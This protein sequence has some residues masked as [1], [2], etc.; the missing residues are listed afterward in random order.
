[1]MRRKEIE[2]DNDEEDEDV[3]MFS[4][5]I[6]TIP[7]KPIMSKVVKPSTASVGDLLFQIK[8]NPI[9]MTTM[10]T[11]TSSS[12]VDQMEWEPVAGGRSRR[13]LYPSDAV[14]LRRHYHYHPAIHSTRFAP[15]R[16]RKH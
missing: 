16:C 12:I 2:D 3:S 13:Y 1:M 14:H 9:P 5:P 15:L 10:N 4:T 8:T 7:A 11:K 6:K